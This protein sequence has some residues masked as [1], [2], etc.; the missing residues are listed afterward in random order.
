MVTYAAPLG[1]G[2]DQ[3]VLIVRHIFAD[4]STILSFYG[5]LDPPSVV[6]RVG[7]CVARGALVGRIGKPRTSPHLHFEIRSHRPNEPGPGYWSVDPTL[8]GWKPPSQFIWDNRITTAPGVQWT[9]SLTSGFTIGLGMLTDDTFGVIDGLHLVGIDLSGAGLRWSQPISYRSTAATLDADGSTLYTANFV[10]AVAAFRLPDPHGVNP[11][12]EIGPSVEPM[13]QIKHDARGMPTLMPLAGGG[14]AVA[15]RGQM[16]GLSPAGRLLWEQDEM[17]RPFD[18]ALMDD[19]LIFT[20]EGRNGPVWTIDQSGP[21]AWQ[22]PISGRPVVVGDRI[23]VYATDGIYCLNPETLSAELLY[24]LPRG[25]PSLGDIVALPDGGLLVAHQDIY[26]RRLILLNGDGTV[27]WERS[28]SGLL[29]GQQRLLMLD[30]RPFLVSQNYTTFSSDEISIF[31]IDLKGAELA[32]IFTGG[33]RDPVPGHT[34][35]FA[36][37]DDRIL[38]NIGGSRMVVLDTQLAMEAISQE[39]NLQ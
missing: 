3:G 28:Y 8:A 6:L 32:R 34:S 13:W 37:G 38:I 22:A 26:D 12:A 25:S 27:R 4:G 31:S 15:V 33:T 9:R 18:W 23:F 11:S 2:V 24:A 10:G 19:Q 17:G 1:W 29:Q 36:I 39:T 21:L 30:R 14:V 20:L 7:D 5:H 16:F 35:A